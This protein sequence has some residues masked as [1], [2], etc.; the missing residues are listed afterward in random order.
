MARVVCPLGLE[1]SSLT[2]MCKH[3][4]IVKQTYQGRKSRGWTERQALGIDLPPAIIC[5][6]GIRFETK[7]DMTKHYG[8]TYVAYKQRRQKGFTE[9]QALGIDPPP[10]KV[11]VCPNGL[12]FK[13][14]KIM[15]SHYGITDTTYYNRIKD[16]GWTERQALGI[17]PPPPIKAGKRSVTCPR[18]MVFSTQLKMLEYY[19]LNKGT[20]KHR[21]RVGW[22][23]AQAL[24]LDPPPTWAVSK[25]VGLEP[26]S[27]NTRLSVLQK[28]HLVQGT[29]F[30]LVQDKETLKNY[31][32][33]EEQIKTYP[34][35]IQKFTKIKD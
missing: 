15:S 29:Q 24:G 12:K 3:Y 9:R 23:L 32:L 22:T 13:S 5:P 19:G 26:K 25:P 4:G 16:Y 18:G 1:F 7:K 21:I 28:E 17:D 6:N 31:V 2:A 35:C 20:Y 10:Q 8:V 34:L 33:T 14:I 27:W 30:Y 11:V